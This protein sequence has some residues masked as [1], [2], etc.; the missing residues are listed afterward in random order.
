[1]DSPDDPESVTDYVAIHVKTDGKWLLAC[2]RDWDVPPAEP[3]PH[4]R[5]E[6]LAWLVGEWIE[7]GPD[8]NVHTV[9]KWHDNGNFLMEEF[10]VQIAGEVAM[11]GTVR[12]GWD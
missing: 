4:D 3:T 7:E 5:L 1:M 6:E 11:S 2:V 10:K 12:V 9:W 8:S